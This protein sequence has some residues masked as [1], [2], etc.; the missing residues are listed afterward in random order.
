MLR[1]CSRQLEALAAQSRP[2]YLPIPRQ[3]FAAR[4]YSRCSPVPSTASDA[5]IS[6][7]RLALFRVG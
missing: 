2:G 7:R 4:W 6:V 3:H 1:V 5:A